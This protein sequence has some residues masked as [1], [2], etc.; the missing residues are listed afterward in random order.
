VVELNLDNAERHLKERVGSFYDDP[1]G[2]VRYIFPWGEPET[3]LAGKDGPDK[4]QAELLHDVGEHVRNTVKSGPTGVKQGQDTTGRFAVVSGHGV[5]KSTVMAWLDIWFLS[6]R[7]HP[8]IVTTANTKKQLETKTWRELAVWKNLAINKHWFDLTATKICLK[9]YPDTW[10]G[11]AI[12]WSK[13]K[14]EAFAGTHA[15]HVMV[16]FDE[17]SII[18]DSIWETTEGAMTQYGAFWFVFG[19]PTRNTGRFS[20]CFGKYRHLWKTY[21]VDSRESKIATNKEQIATWIR[22]Y[23][24]DSDFVRIRVKGVFPRAGTKQLIPGDIVEQAQQRRYHP[25]DFVHMPKILGVDIARHGDDQTVLIRR[26]GLVAFGMQKFRI[27]NLK[28][29]ATVVAQEIN[30]WRPDQVFVDA[31]G[32]WGWGVVDILQDLGHHNVMGVE[33]GR[34]ASLPKRFKNVRAEMWW[35]MREWLN[36]GGAIPDDY[37]LYDDLIGLEYDYTNEQTIFIEKKEDMKARGLSSPDCADALALTFA[38]HVPPPSVSINVTNNQQVTLPP[39][40]DPGR[41]QRYQS[42]NQQTD[43]VGGYAL[44]DWME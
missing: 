24:E 28:D 40:V 44:P 13:E 32:G 12:P 16:K 7:P 41:P 25:N 9:Q 43:G 20:Q 1:L 30:I 22:E 29:V 5:G 38:Y 33:V 6:T 18:E 36:S 14:P 3:P 2:F 37:E 35:K 17:A 31:T 21:H 39:W 27:P 15:N 10:F 26:Q 4:W 42:V 23:G 19:N 8:Q 34:T 11:A